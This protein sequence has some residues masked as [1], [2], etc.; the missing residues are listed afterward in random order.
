MD[1]LERFWSKVDKNG[2]VPAHRPDLGPC[3]IWKGA[4]NGPGYGYFYLGMID[5]KQVKE[6]AHRFVYCI[7]VGPLKDKQEPDHLC[8]V[9]A[10]CNPSHLE[11]VTRRENLRRGIG[12]IGS[13]MAQE[14]CVNGHSFTSENTSVR[15]N[16]TRQCRECDAS[17]H[18]T[19]RIRL[20][21]P[22]RAVRGHYARVLL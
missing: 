14:T 2:P 4:T 7:C 10:C 6:G 5:G 11:S 16:G 3:W 20:G 9:P 15:K 1:I 8:R 13:K 17:A 12:F 18:R 19:R 21:L 22:V